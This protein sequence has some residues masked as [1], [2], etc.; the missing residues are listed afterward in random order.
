M[1]AAPRKPARLE[2]IGLGHGFGRTA[3]YVRALHNVSILLESGTFN[4][5]RGPSGS[6][7]STLLSLLSGLVRPQEG[8]VLVEGGSIW[9]GGPRGAR[10]F[11]AEQCG[12]VFQGS[13]LIPAMRALDQVALPLRLLG[14]DRAQAER[15][16]RE[17]LDLVGL[18][19]RAASTPEEMSGGQ[20]QRV[21]FARML[22]KRPRFVFCDEPTSALDRANGQ[23]IGQMLMELAGR[24]R[25]AVLCMTHDE[26]L[27]PFASNVIE[28][29]DG[30]IVSGD[31]R[32]PPPS[33]PLIATSSAQR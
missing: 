1:I 19:E 23:I 26:R 25:A 30:Q 12:F 29:E 22:A 33:F 13:G 7:K 10:Q 32:E 5:L 20:N 14:T 28:I 15:A 17:A 16:A 24:D 11:R 8:Q 9:A 3:G 6:G 21:A 18:L 31:K 4:I 2:G 27:L